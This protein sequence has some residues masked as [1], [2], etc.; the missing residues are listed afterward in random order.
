[1]RWRLEHK[2][3]GTCYFKAWLRRD[4]TPEGGSTVSTSISY[5]W[6]GT[7]NPCLIDPTKSVDDI[8]N[9]I[10]PN[11]TEEGV[12]DTDGTVRI[13]DLLKYSCLPGYEPDQSDPDNP[14]PNGFPD[15]AWEPA[16]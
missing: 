9:L 11:P 16:A 6:T 12:P 15:P 3:T 1:M 5:E 4:W 2:P 13:W 10:I 14:Q 8:S 7:G